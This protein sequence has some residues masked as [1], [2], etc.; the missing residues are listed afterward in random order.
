MRRKKVC[1]CVLHADWPFKNF[2]SAFILMF[3]DYFFFFPVYPATKENL[4][5][6]NFRKANNGCEIQLMIQGVN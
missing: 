4:E 2:L 5:P 6:L 3:L 1:M